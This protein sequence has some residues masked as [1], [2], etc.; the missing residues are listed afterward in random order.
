MHIKLD[1]QADNKYTNKDDLLNI[2]FLHKEKEDVR[3]GV[4]T[5]TTVPWSLGIT[6]FILI[7]IIIQRKRGKRNEKA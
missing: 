7:L 2:E 3:T 1:E 6:N 5:N 4:L